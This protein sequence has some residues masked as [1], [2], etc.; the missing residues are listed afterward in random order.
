MKI[1][2]TTFKEIDGAWIAEDTLIGSNVTIFPGAV[3]GR[4]PISTGFQTR[5]AAPESLSPLV[6]GDGSVIG[7]HAVIY[8]GTKIGH[9]CLIGDTACIREQVV[10]GDSCIIAMGVTINY[11]TSIGSRVKIMDNSHITGNM[12]IEDGVFIA[13][14]VGSANDNSMGREAALKVPAHLRSRSGPVVRRNATIGGC[15]CLLPGVEIGENAV[16]GANSLVS[17]SIPARVLA[18]GSPAR[19]IRELRDDEIKP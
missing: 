16:V 10:I 12:I 8:R 1:A 6:I 4:P 15:T 11:N 2:S 18:L 9:D 14:L 7:A 13:M 17:R 5:K 3:L 19:V